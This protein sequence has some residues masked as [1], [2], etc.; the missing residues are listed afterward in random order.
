MLRVEERLLAL[1]PQLGLVRLQERLQL[2]LVAPV[3]TDERVALH[4]LR[5]HARPRL[6]EHALPHGLAV[7]S[8][9]V[10]RPRRLV[11]IFRRQR[12]RRVAVTMSLHVVVA[13]DEQLLDRLAVGAPVLGEHLEPRL[14]HELQLVHE[15]AVRHVAR[16]DHAVGLAVAEELQRPLEHRHLLLVV[17]VDVAQ[18]AECQLGRDAIHCVRRP[19]R[20]GRDAIYCVRRTRI[21][22]SKLRPSQQKSCAACCR[23]RQEHSP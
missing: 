6:I 23:A 14:P 18:D 17:D 7:R 2:L 19:V 1:Q 4:L 10:R 11:G 16:D 9:A 12:L 3:R 13:V 15:P 5:V 8:D 22:R 20:T 21:G